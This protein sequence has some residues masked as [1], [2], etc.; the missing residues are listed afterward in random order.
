MTAR[1][2]PK[3]PRRKQGNTRPKLKTY[4]APDKSTAMVML[5]FFH[6][7]MSKTA[8]MLGVDRQL[9][10]RW[11]DEMG[12]EPEGE[13]A[14][15]Y[16]Y[17][18]GRVAGVLI[19]LIEALSVYVLLKAASEDYSQMKILI[20]IVC[21]KIEDI[22]KRLERVRPEKEFAPLPDADLDIPVP[23][24]ASQTKREPTEAELAW[25]KEKDRYENMVKLIIAEAQKEG[26]DCSREAAITS[27]VKTKPEAAVYFEDMIKDE[28][29]M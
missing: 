13:V 10:G 7:D 25:Q 17:G 28:Y 4:G 1:R 14:E 26:S 5:E 15:R 21:D 16:A 3:L 6:G 12:G 18:S 29:S 27:I 11:R 24:A 2:D 22:H 20:G 8:R 9:L 19:D 23:A